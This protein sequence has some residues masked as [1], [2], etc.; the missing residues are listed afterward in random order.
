MRL[1]TFDTHSDK[2]QTKLNKILK[3]GAHRPNSKQ[4]TILIQIRQ[5]LC[6]QILILA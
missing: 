5:D 2:V 6:N 1:A 4:D 3:F